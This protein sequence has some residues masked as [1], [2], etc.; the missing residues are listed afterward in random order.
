M[1]TVTCPNCGD[2]ST[3]SQS[4]YTTPRLSKWCCG[5]CNTNSLIRDWY[6]PKHIRKWKEKL[7]EKT[8]T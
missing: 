8:T 6:I 5:I 3:E 4:I 1:V 2:R 7:D